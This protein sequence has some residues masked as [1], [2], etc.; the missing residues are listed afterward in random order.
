MGSCPETLGAP[1][2]PGHLKQ[3][4]SEFVLRGHG[5]HLSGWGTTQ[6]LRGH[7]GHPSGWGTTWTGLGSRE[8]VLGLG[9]RGQVLGWQVMNSPGALQAPGAPSHGAQ[10][11]SSG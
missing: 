5:G 10:G 1:W 4:K 11:E 7:G 8:E 2:H 3:A 9:Q 6:V